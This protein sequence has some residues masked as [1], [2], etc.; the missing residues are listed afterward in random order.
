VARRRFLAD[1]YDAVSLRSIA[2]EAA[3]DPALINYHFGSKRGLFGAVLA[4]TVN[5]PD[6]LARELAGPLNSLPERLVRAVV[7]AWDDPASGGSLRGVLQAAL[8]EPEVARLVR[9]MAEREIIGR[10]AE[11]LGGAD[12]PRRAALAASQIM[13]LLVGRYVLHIEPLASMSADELAQRM[14]PTLRTAL[15]GPRAATRPARP[16]MSAGD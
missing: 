14:G 16:V 4:L 6:L 7:T 8:R 3:V 11:R 2:A 13:G 12:A 9:G 1:G 15:A 5:P 10:I